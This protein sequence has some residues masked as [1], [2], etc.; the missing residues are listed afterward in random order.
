MKVFRILTDSPERFLSTKVRLPVL[1][2][3]HCNST[4]MNFLAG[5]SEFCAEADVEVAQLV[6]AIAAIAAA[7]RS[8]MIGPSA[9][10][11][12]KLSPPPTIG[13]ETS[14]SLLSSDFDFSLAFLSDIA[15]HETKARQLSLLT[16]VKC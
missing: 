5:S 14:V 2:G 12:L 6:A 3:G 11:G 4:G 13:S 1:P 10:P 7:L 16:T 8:V 15:P 9:S